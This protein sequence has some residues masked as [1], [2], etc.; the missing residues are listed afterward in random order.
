[1]A[2]AGTPEAVLRALNQVAVD[3]ANTPKAAQLRET[4]PFQQ[5]ENLKETGRL[6]GMPVWTAGSGSGYQL[7]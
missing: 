4:S 1:M 7:D 3:G 2:P 6:V 5:A